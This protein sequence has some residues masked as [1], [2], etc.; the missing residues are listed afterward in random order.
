MTLMRACRWP[1]LFSLAFL[2]AVPAP[3]AERTARFTVEVKVQG[4]QS[5]RAGTDW[6]RTDIDEHY[7][8]TTHVRS[9]GELQNVNPKDPAFAQQQLAKAAAVQRT[10]ARQLGKTGPQP[11]TEAE[12]A[13]AQQALAAQ[14]QRE[15]AACGQDTACLI[16]VATRIGQQSAAIVYPTAPA[17][18]AAED[19]ALLAE[20]DDPAGYRYMYYAGYEGCP[21]EIQIRIQRRSRGEYA[22]VAGTIPWTATQTGD[23]RGTDIDHRMQCLSAT[24]V[25]DERTRQIFTDGWGTP[26]VVGRY[27]SEDRMQGRVVN[28][29]SPLSGDAE[30]LEWVASVLRQAP[31][32]GSRSTTLVPR[33]IRSG[34]SP[35]GAEIGGA[36]QVR[37]D[38]RFDPG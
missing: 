24:T 29:Q 3:A 1:W 5:W 37:V 31:A 21:T 19:A 11:R 14:A 32:S 12:Y 23:S 35:D 16:G 33:L 36:L 18:D 13:A 34:H 22:D 30:A 26:A 10:V 2:A 4:H 8:I 25:Y 6:A 7:R 28:D 27:E 20:D 15:Q 9:D 38:W 17:A